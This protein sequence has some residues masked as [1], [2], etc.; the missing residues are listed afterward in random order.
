MPVFKKTII[1]KKKV[2]WNKKRFYLCSPFGLKKRK[3][4]NKKVL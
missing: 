3:K 4:G 1:F 2:C